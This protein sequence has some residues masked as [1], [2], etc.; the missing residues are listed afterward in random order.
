M[1]LSEQELALLA[2]MA[3]GRRLLIPADGVAIL[4]WLTTERFPVGGESLTLARAA[5]IA[6][7]RD[8]QAAGIIWGPDAVLLAMGQPAT[9]SIPAIPARLL[10]LSGLRT[11]KYLKR[12]LTRVSGVVDAGS[13]YFAGGAKQHRAVRIEHRTLWSILLPNADP[14]VSQT[15]SK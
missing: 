6:D 4:R 7:D 1:K 2:V 8:L 14:N 3:G 15:V 13:R 10:A 5:T 12:E 9:R 11:V